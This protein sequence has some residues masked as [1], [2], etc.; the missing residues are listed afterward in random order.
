MSRFTSGVSTVAAAAFGSTAPLTRRL[1]EA[2][3]ILRM[4]M[5]LSRR[6]SLVSLQGGSGASS[7]AAYSSSVLATR[8]S[9]MVLGVDAAGGPTGL[10]W[11]AGLSDSPRPEASRRRAAARRA[12]DARDGLPVTP[13]GLYTLALGAAPGAQVPA[14]VLGWVDQV[15]PI[16]R[17]F[18]VVCTDWG[19]R[20]PA[21]DLLAVASLSHVV[22]LVTRADRS[23]CERAAAAVPA[24]RQ[25]EQNPRV[26]LVVVDVDHSGLRCARLIRG[27]VDA[28][29]L[30]VPYDRA[31][32]GAAPVGSNALDR[33]TRLAYLRLTTELMTAAQAQPATRRLEVVA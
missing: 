10:L 2:D 6:I 18:D 30:T 31:R 28:P 17:F 26:V 7:A 1:T 21:V 16:A 19:V 9:S 3:A 33:R 32:A 27:Q 15:S 14:P 13:S 12:S 8:R 22:C 29:V 4:P 25:A 20:Q 11:Q 24:L 5:P 23:G